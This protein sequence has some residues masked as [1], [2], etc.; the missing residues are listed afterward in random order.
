MGR[1]VDFRRSVL[2]RM[3]R[4]SIETKCLFSLAGAGGGVSS[5]YDRVPSVNRL[6]CLR[7]DLETWA[8]LWPRDKRDLPLALVRAV[9]STVFSRLNCAAFLRVTLRRSALSLT[10]SCRFRSSKAGDRL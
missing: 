6:G 4:A 5:L 8:M 3:T 10:V 2:L 9:S 1:S 7:I